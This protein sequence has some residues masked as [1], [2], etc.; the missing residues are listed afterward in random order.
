MSILRPIDAVMI[1]DI[2]GPFFGIEDDE[3]DED[4]D[5]E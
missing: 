1:D 4:D 3:P 5:E 2:L